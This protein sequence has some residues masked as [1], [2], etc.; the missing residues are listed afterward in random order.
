MRIIISLVLLTAIQFTSFGQTISYDIPDGYENDIN[1]ED[2]KKLVDI[3]VPIVSKR[4]TIESVKAGTIKLKHGQEMGALNL[5]NLIL[6]CAAVKDKTKW[7]EVIQGHFE[8]LFSSL[9]ADKKID[10]TNYET[11]K[12]YLSI[13]IYPATTVIERGGVEKVVA[14]TDLDGTYTLLMLDL[15]G[16]FKAV[17][18]DIFILWKKNIDEVFN[19][20]Q[21][22]VN[23][24][25]IEKV[26]QQFDIDGAKIEISFLGNEDYAASYALDLIHNSPELVGEWGSVVAI[27]NK[28]LVNVCKISRD[29]P[30]DFVK[31]IQRTKPLIA[32]SYREHPQPISTDYFWYYKGKFTKIAILEKENGDFNVLSP[33]G[34]TDLMTEKN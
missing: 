25:K 24:Q 26:T 7:G 15:P 4:Y 23:K 1:K 31:F 2:Y 13:R 34:L 16:A 27:P 10:P 22:N 33:M 18:K 14:K 19:V 29:K 20:A 21:D 3:S 30:V 9:D 28:G 11:I 12:K 8:N 6:K 32:K 17:Q 5:H